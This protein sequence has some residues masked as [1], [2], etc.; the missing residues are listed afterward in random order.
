MIDPE[1]QNI[2]L[3][4][5][6][7]ADRVPSRR[8]LTAALCYLTGGLFAYRDASGGTPLPLRDPEHFDLYLGAFEE[9]HR[10]L[11]PGV[12]E[13]RSSHGV[14]VANLSAQPYE[15]EGY[16]IPPADALIAQ[17][18]DEETGEP[19]DWLTTFGR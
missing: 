15:Y 11:A 4:E 13:R 8:R 16:G 10:E 1:S 18:R 6:P 19:I 5:E 3:V 12:Y 7:E 2:L 17:T 9:P 14:V